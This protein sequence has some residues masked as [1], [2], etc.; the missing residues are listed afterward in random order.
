MHVR[1]NSTA[2]H[3]EYMFKTEAKTFLVIV[4]MN[5]AIFQLLKVGT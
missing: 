4:K 3:S 5:V 2:V 1:C